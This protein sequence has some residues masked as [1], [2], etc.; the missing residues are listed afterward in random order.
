MKGNINK[1][2]ELA[3]LV[4]KE[5]GE[6]LYFLGLIHRT[7]YEDKWDLLIIADWIKENNSV[8]DLQYILN[9]LNTVFTDT[10][11]LKDVVLYKPDFYF[12]FE[13][14]KADSAEA[15]LELKEN[16]VALWDDGYITLVPIVNNL[17]ELPDVE[18]VISK[19]DVTTSF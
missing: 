9:C 14:K 11:F 15:F 7:D 4:L 3:D 6:I 8:D 16:Q 13:L 10:D 12:S 18:K 5:K 2:R 1:L 19:V 17:N